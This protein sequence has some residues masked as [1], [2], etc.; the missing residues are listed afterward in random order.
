MGSVQ[1]V[2]EIMKN[3]LEDKCPECRQQKLTIVKMKL[4]R[5]FRF[6]KPEY[7][8]RFKEIECTTKRCKYQK[9]EVK[10]YE[11]Y[12]RYKNSARH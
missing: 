11:Y 8:L 3:N 6:S 7:T 5:N 2:N 10:D 1:E 4:K 9:T 12:W